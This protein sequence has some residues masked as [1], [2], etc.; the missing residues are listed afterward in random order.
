VTHN[1]GFR[2]KNF[3]GASQEFFSKAGSVDDTLNKLWFIVANDDPLLAM[4]LL[5]WLRD[6]RGGAGQRHRFREIIKQAADTQ[7]KPWILANLSNIPEYGRYDDL[8]SLHGTSLSDEVASFIVDNLTNGLCAKW[9]PRKGVIFSWIRD[10]MGI[11][12]KELRQILVANTDV[13]ENTMCSKHWDIIYTRVPSGARYKYRRAFLRNDALRYKEFLK[14]RSELPTDFTS[15]RNVECI[16]MESTHAQA[17]VDAMLQ[18]K[19]VGNADKTKQTMLLISDMQPKAAAGLSECRSV[20]VSLEH[21]VDA[22]FPRPVVLHWNL[23]DYEGQLESSKN[24]AFIRMILRAIPND[25]L[26][27]IKMRMLCALVKYNVIEP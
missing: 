27:P 8:H 1:N 4:K 11:T 19:I 26:I 24:A 18:A 23:V 3:C 9:M 2:C 21:W 17:S 20:E 15:F 5:F 7:Y 13:V 6:P 12:N 25:D 22:G 14:S 10:Y 16:P